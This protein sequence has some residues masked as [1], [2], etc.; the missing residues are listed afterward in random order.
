V[1]HAAFEVA[2]VVRTG[3]IPPFVSGLTEAQRSELTPVA[4]ALH[5]AEMSHRG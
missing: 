5:A 1:L 2:D 3:P 4:R